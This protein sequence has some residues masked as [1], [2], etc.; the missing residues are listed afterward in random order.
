MALAPVW[1][2]DAG[3]LGVVPEGK[4]YKVR[5][6]AVDPDFPG[7]PSKIT[8]SLIAGAL[9]SGVQIS[10]TG[11]IEG[12]PISAADF[13]GVP[14][15]V[16]ENTT[17]KF[18]I[19]VTDDEDRIA[20]R[21]FTLT[22][23]GQ[24][25]PFWVTPAGRIGTWFDAS[26]VS[27][28]FEVEDLDPDDEFTVT[29]V[30][31]SLPD[32][33]TLSDDGLIS[34]VTTPLINLS[35][36]IPGFDLDGIGF[37]EFPFDFRATSISQNYQF[38]LKLSDGKDVVLRQF[39]I[40][41]FSRNSMTAD[42]SEVTI[43]SGN[44]TAD[45]IAVRSPY[46]INNVADLGRFRHDN[47]FAHKFDGVDTDSDQISYYIAWGPNSPSVAASNIDITVDDI[48]ITAD[49]SSSLESLGL[50]LDPDSG[51]LTGVFPDIGLTE[52]EYN[53]GVKVYKTESTEI[54]S[55]LYLTS[56]TLF[57]N[58]DT[59]VTWITDPNLG[60]IDNGSISILNVEAEHADTELFYRLTT[61]GECNSLPQGLQLM[62]SGNIIGQ[63][64]F[65]VSNFDGDGT[66]FDED[67]A[68]RR[69]NDPT[70]FDLTY[71]F[72]VEA[73]SANGIVSVTREFTIL[74]NKTYS[75][76]YNALYCKALPPVADRV[77]VN[78]LLSNTTVIPPE[79]L[80][81]ADDPNFGLASSVV[82]EHAFGLAPSTVAAYFA[83]VELNHYNKNLVLGEIKTAR[84][85]DADENIIYEVVYSHIVD[86]LVNANNESIPS[87][88][89]INYQ[90][91]DD[92]APVF[93]VYP[94]S[95]VNM[96]DQVIDKVGQ[97]SKVLPTWMLS[98][99]EN[100]EVLGFTPAWVIAY[101][102]PGKSKF[103]QYTITEF[104]G[105]QLNLINFEIDRYTL[106]AR[107]TEHWGVTVTVDSTNTTADSDILVSDSDRWKPG[108]STTFDRIENLLGV[109]VD[110]ISITVDS[111]RYINP[112]DPA[113]LPEGYDPRDPGPYGNPYETLF[114]GGCTTFGSPVDVY[115]AT[116][117]MDKY[118]KFPKTNIINNTQ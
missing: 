58:I 3:S 53:F 84:A 49:R 17:S 117:N 89:P 12:I 64:S 14:A 96:R 20:D 8:Y 65:K 74:L 87:S 94:N 76:P 44:I 27:F 100:G 1:I 47:Y 46:I 52:Q 107:L 102:G 37:E 109:T 13:K 31:G 114:D 110:D 104:V 67:F 80:Y 36:G 77:L 54:Q 86:P 19:R 24:D 111:N 30:A 34:G 50:T 33:L 55:I 39:E 5:L 82:Y 15:E 115:D 103:L 16:S 10:T 118:I 22:V 43:D 60:I 98:K 48:S 116:N 26:E 99:Q 61:G 18:A 69:T 108:V 90:A 93:T 88:V 63:V 28:Q 23:S 75:S 45:S 38:T 32:G 56:L 11:T 66:T 68:T 70:T 101:T 51:W 85:L 62:P 4:F 113:I 25:K 91:I 35:G 79:I 72:T 106:D 57:G 42:N 71:T 41:I 9:P 2:T 6:E 83:A 7:D 95:L 78:S 112:A 81:R 40:F 21:T 73:Y 92:G 29:L 97:V 105:T 59:E